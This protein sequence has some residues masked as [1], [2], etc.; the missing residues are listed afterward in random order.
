MKRKVKNFMFKEEKLGVAYLHV[1]PSC[2][3]TQSYTGPGSLYFF[4][5]DAS[6]SDWLCS[7]SFCNFS[8]WREEAAWR[9]RVRE[10]IE[11]NQIRK[12]HIAVTVT[13]HWRVHKELMFDLWGC[14]VREV[15][16]F[17]LA[18]DLGKCCSVWWVPH[19]L[20]SLLLRDKSAITKYFKNI[21]RGWQ[22]DRF[23]FILSTGLFY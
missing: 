6:S 16:L 19:L 11:I 9:K 13:K 5:S 1:L 2:Q 12:H 18:R 21:H 20:L 17:C 8:I 4:S 15:K 3:S 22:S 23:S 10:T 14:W 7:S